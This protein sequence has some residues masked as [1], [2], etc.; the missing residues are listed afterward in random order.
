MACQPGA[1]ASL[2]VYFNE[3]RGRRQYSRFSPS[4]FCIAF[5]D[6]MM[7]G[8]VARMEYRRNI[9]IYIHTQHFGGEK[10]KALTKET[11][12]KTQV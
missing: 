11:T 9:Y 4:F 5:T 1:L 2:P 10:K 8:E 7:G 3:I 6:D 12:W